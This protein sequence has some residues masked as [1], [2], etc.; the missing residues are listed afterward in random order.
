MFS[1]ARFVSS[2]LFLVK[3]VDYDEINSR[4]CFSVSKK[5]VKKAVTRNRLRR[6][7]YGGIAQKIDLIKNNKLILFSYKKQPK[8]QEEVE[9]NIDYILKKSKLIK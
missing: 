5:V 8:N 6:M 2:D 9:S 3:N 4:I 1:K 7:G